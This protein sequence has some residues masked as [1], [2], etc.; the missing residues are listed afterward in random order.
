MAACTR[1]AH[2]H[3]DLCHHLQHHRQTPS[4]TE[5]CAN[6]RIS[7]RKVPLSLFFSTKLV[8]KPLSRRYTRMF[9]TRHNFGE[10]D[11]QTGEPVKPRGVMNHLPCVSDEGK[12]CRRL[13][14]R[15]PSLP[16]KSNIIARPRLTSLSRYN[17]SPFFRLCALSRTSSCL[18]LPTSSSRDRTLSMLSLWHVL[19]DSCKLCCDLVY[20]QNTD[21]YRLF[22]Y[23]LGFMGGLTTAPE[24]LKT[25]NKP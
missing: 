12:S 18:L 8:L 25:F 20:L 24:F 5:A 13:S 22:G 10:A 9:L 14:C 23:D 19:W 4:K 11:G 17:I 1:H 21:Q 15:Y 16:H 3:V 6:Q 7:D 2:V